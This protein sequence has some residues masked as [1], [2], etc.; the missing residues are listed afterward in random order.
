MAV[1]AC[2]L[3]AYRFLFFPLFFSLFF[4]LSF[5]PL[6]LP[7]NYLADVNVSSPL[8]ERLRSPAVTDG[9][10][11]IFRLLPASRI[12]SCLSA[13]IWSSFDR[14]GIVKPQCTEEDACIPRMQLSARRFAR[15]ATK[16][17]ESFRESR[18]RCLSSKTKSSL[19][20]AFLPRLVSNVRDD[21]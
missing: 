11:P 14:W 15:K 2:T 9:G 5:F 20:T 3:T 19:S 10:L 8:S 1:A 16:T 13:C 7:S 12:S 21:S 4:F 6:P 18:A 17:G